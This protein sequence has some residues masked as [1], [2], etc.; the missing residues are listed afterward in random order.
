[1]QIDTTS[2]Q[3][4]LVFEIFAALAEFKRI[5]IS[6]RTKAGLASARARGR[7]GSAPNK[8]IQAKLRPA[9]AS[10]EKCEHNISDLCKEL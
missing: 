4:K 1:M 9:M 8:M 7:L 6:E 10:M 3:G 2:T 5:L